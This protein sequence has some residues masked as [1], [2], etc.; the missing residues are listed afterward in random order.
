MQN[1]PVVVSRIDQPRR[2]ATS[3]NADAGENADT[4][5]LLCYTRTIN[6]GRVAFRYYIPRCLSR[7]MKAITGVVTSTRHRSLLNYLPRALESRTWSSG[8]LA[9]MRISEDKTTLASRECIIRPVSNNFQM[10]NLRDN[11]TYPFRA[12]GREYTSMAPQM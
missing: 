3:V 5:I 9:T 6:T 2:R 7:T 12:S 4:E 11:I 10:N 1:V 8:Q